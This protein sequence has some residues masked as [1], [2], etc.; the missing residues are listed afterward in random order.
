LAPAH[1]VLSLTPSRPNAVDRRDLVACLIDQFG[2]PER[3]A[4]RYAGLLLP[5]PRRPDRFLA[6][7]KLA[8]ESVEL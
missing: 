4:G 3:Q 2:L 8:P 7:L 6:R 5:S 1:E